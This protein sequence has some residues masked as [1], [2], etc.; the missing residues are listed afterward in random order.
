[1]KITDKRRF[2]GGHPNTGR[3]KGVG[4]YFT[5]KNVIDD[6]FVDL[7]NKLKED[8]KSMQIINNEFVQN[9]LF[10]EDENIGWVYILQNP[11]DGLTKIGITSLQNPKARLCH[12]K[13]HIDIKVIYLSKVAEYG[14][15]EN[16]LHLQ[17]QNKR[18]RGEWFNLSETDI[19]NAITQIN[20]I[21]Y[22][23]YL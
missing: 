16:E 23:K 12:Y 8:A 21:E 3:K 2:N 22:N 17:Y 11:N 4:K 10:A 15:L 14:K 19:V 18:I 1:M 9:K 7:Y 13:T 6:V 5:L 20:S